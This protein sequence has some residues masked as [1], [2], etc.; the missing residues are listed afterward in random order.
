MLTKLFGRNKATEQANKW[1][2][3]TLLVFSLAGLLSSTVLSV[4]KLHL[5]QDPSAKLSCNIN[6]FLNCAS[7]MKTSQAAVIGDI[8]NSF[9]GMIGFAM[10]VAF[11]ILLLA[12]IKNV[13]KWV[14]WAAQAGFGAGMLFAYWLY[15]Q[16]VFA[17][18][19]LCPWCLVVTFSTTILFVT[20]LHYNLRENTFNLN[21][22]W[23]K[24]TKNWLQNDYDKLITAIWIFI[25]V[26]T[27]LYKFKDGIFG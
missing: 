9:F 7:V 17:I 1:I 18:E 20:M 13:P 24:R 27:A 4:E 22:T 25:L 19:V 21:K 15:Y 23:Q 6:V 12:G 14:F 2:F 3:G 26:F 8:P 16:S 5:L 11:A 10:A